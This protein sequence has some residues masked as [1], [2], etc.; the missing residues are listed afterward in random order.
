ARALSAVRAAAPAFGE[1]APAR[2]ALRVEGAGGLAA[3][4]RHDHAGPIRSTATVPV[5]LTGDRRRVDRAVAGEDAGGVV[6]AGIGRSAVGVIA[7]ETSAGIRGAG[8]IEGMARSVGA[9][10][11][12]ILG[13]VLARRLAGP[14]RAAPRD[15]VGVRRTG[16]AGRTGVGTGPTAVD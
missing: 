9:Q 2:R 1:D 11:R 16:A 10:L 5:R 3:Q 13:A 4:L 7:A 6:A 14:A 8:G 15:A 12:P